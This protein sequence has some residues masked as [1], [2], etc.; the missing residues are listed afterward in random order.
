MSTNRLLQ[1]LSFLTAL[2]SK[3]IWTE[4][5]SSYVLSSYIKFGMQ[6][7]FPYTSKRKIS[8]PSGETT[9]RESKQ[10]GNLKVLN[11]RRHLHRR[12]VSRKKLVPRKSRS[13]M[14]LIVLL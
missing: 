11:R 5:L 8:S 3:G 6:N 2:L 1:T 9:A 13:S 12:C 7:V 14:N 10:G 4:Y